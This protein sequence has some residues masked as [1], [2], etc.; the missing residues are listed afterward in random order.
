MG[1]LDVCR[2]N[3]PIF[4]KYQKLGISNFFYCVADVAK[5]VVFPHKLISNLKYSK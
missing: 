3:Q 1:W 4:L 2:P 5:Y